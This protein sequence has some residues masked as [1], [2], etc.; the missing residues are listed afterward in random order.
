MSVPRGYDPDRDIVGC[1]ECG[2]TLDAEWTNVGTFAEREPA[3]VLVSLSCPVSRTHELDAA[4][5]ALKVV[6]VAH[7]DR[8]MQGSCTLLGLPRWRKAGW[9]PTDS[10]LQTA[11]EMVEDRV[12]QLSAGVGG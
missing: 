7:P 1:P 3:A 5:A 9:Y 2:E 12:R 4:Y 6:A 10:E 8:P 11:T